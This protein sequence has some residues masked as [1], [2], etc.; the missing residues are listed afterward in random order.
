MTDTIAQS[1]PRIFPSLRRPAPEPQRCYADEYLLNKFADDSTALKITNAL[2]TWR[3]RD[4]PWSWR[5]SVAFPF[6]EDTIARRAADP[7]AE[8]D[9]T[10]LPLPL[11]AV[12]ISSLET[13]LAACA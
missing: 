12:F 13:A 6:L 11:P 5:S 1:R 10:T 3:D 7:K 2:L 9:F 8:L 4:V